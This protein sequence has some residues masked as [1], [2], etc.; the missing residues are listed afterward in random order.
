MQNN[1]DEVSPASRPTKK[2]LK[3]GP[4][5]IRTLLLGLDGSG[6]TRLLYQFKLGESVKTI[7]TIG[8]NVETLI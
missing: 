7:L 5:E 1:D 2:K 3:E 4:M 6:K 8:F